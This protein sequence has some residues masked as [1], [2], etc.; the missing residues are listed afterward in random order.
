MNPFDHNATIDPPPTDIIRRAHVLKCL[1]PLRSALRG[2]PAEARDRALRE[3]NALYLRAGL[4]L[5][6]LSGA[7][8]CSASY[9]WG[10]FW[11]LGLQTHEST[12]RRAG[13]VPARTIAL[14][15]PGA[16]AVIDSPEKAH[17]L[18]LLIADAKPGSVFAWCVTAGRPPIKCTIRI[19]KWYPWSISGPKLSPCGQASPQC[20][21]TLRALDSEP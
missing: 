1:K 21:R 9:L 7:V 19:A 18:G 16:F 11:R 8:R 10:Q 2:N 17:L 4:T 3:A 6:E 15:Q 5:V 12:H 13:H 14:G 20:R